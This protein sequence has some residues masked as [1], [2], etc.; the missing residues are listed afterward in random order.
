MKKSLR[1][2]VTLSILASSILFAQPAS[3]V[4]IGTLYSSET[5]SGDVACT[6]SG[7]MTISNNVVIDDYYCNGTANIPSGVTSIAGGAFFEGQLSQ[8]TIPNTVT[9][10]EDRAFAYSRALTSVVIPNS[11]TYLGSSIFLG[12]ISLSSVTLPNSIT[13]IPYGTFQGAFQ[14]TSSTSTSITIPSSVTVIEAAAF[15]GAS[16]LHTVI[17]P[18]S[19]TMIEH[20]A[21]ANGL[22]R[23]TVVIGE[24]V[25]S[26]GE[27]A[28]ESNPLL[29]SLVIGSN[30]SSIANNAFNGS[31]SLTSYTYCGS[32]TDE[33]MSN[34]GFGGKTNTCRVATVAAGE[35]PNS[36]IATF[37]SSGVKKAEIPASSALPAIKLDFLVTAPSL[38]TVSPTTNPASPS[39][40]PFMT[41]DSLQIVDINPSNHDGSDVKI[42]LDGA[43]T[44]NLYHYTGGH[45][46]ELLPRT[47]EN[48]Q[49]CG[50]TNSFSPFVAAPVNPVTAPGAPTIGTATA[51]GTTTATISFTAPASDGGS[52]IVSYTA[53]STPGGITAIVEQA[54]SGTISVTGLNTS[55][56]Y[57]F[58]VTAFN[59]FSDSV[60]SSASN[61]ITTESVPAI[62]YIA[63]TPMPYL[64]TLTSPKMNLKDGKAVCTPGTYNAGYTLDGVIQGSAAANFDPINFVYD[65]L[66]N[67]VA[68]TSKSVSSASTSTS[69]DVQALPSGSLV[70]CSVTVSANSLSNTDKSTDNAAAASQGLIAQAQEIKTAETKYAETVSANAK[71]YQKALIDNRATWRKEI[72]TIQSSYKEALDRIKAKGG[73]KAVTETSAALKLRI[74]ASKKSAADYAASKPAALAAKEAANKAALDVKSSAIAKA[75]SRYG[76]FIESIGYGVLIP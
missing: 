64:K 21:F 32:L 24:G 31:D 3:A 40:T 30:V 46:V 60:A 55:T 66:I 76:T 18:D 2:L 12:A 41:S 48:N 75:N 20:D 11:V 61:S 62:V 19:V 43:S 38:V 39:A 57:T 63:P 25:T 4:V 68:Q 53:T 49:V 22:N 26:I 27:H 9:R 69:W 14:N 51:T 44:D 29:T 54:G 56:S 35:L 34:K 72:E 33:Q 59:G 1:V 58:S 36:K 47:Y 23:H 73:P 42:C 71:A 16:N 67:G 10:I 8:V 70:A 50:I 17:I 37:S 7:W 74:A 6:T 65:L 28:F 13:T 52:S 15:N 5:G 45:W